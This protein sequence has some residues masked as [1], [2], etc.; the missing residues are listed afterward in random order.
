MELFENHKHWPYVKSICQ[1]L[2]KNHFQAYIAGGA[3]RDAFLK[4][5]IKDFDIATNALPQDIASLFP[6]TLLVGESFGVVKVI[7]DPISVDVATFRQDG[8]YSDGRHPNEISFSS[9]QEDALRRDFTINALFYDPFCQKIVDF[10]NGQKDLKNQ[11]VRTV[12]PP[13]KRFEED[14]L[15]ALRAVRLA[16]ELGFFIEDKTFKALFHVDL[17]QVSKERITEEFKKILL[18]PLRTKGLEDLKQTGLLKFIL[19]EVY[20][21][22]KSSQENDWILKKWF[23]IKKTLSSISQT[24]LSLILATLFVFFE[25]SLSDLKELKLSKQHSQQILFL[26]ESYKK[27]PSLCLEEALELFN[28]E[29]GPLLMEFL[30]IMNFQNLETIITRYQSLMEKNGKL[31]SCFLT[32]EDLKNM[33]LTPGAEFKEILKECLYLQWRKDITSY[34][35]ALSWLKK[36]SK[37]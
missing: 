5:R 25:N 13:Q 36:R 7:E 6:K 15:R 33:G 19:P 32:G 28:Q 35:E 9:P 4:K 31:P 17:K 16:T 20:K 11:R 24:D 34:E 23:E 26:I 14:K 30:E 2:K 29:D 3:V 10:V 8:T 27:L 18:S 21:N 1:K 37:L 22:L 12:G